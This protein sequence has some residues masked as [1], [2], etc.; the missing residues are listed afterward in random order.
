MYASMD[1]EGAAARLVV[2]QK[3]CKDSEQVL[4]HLHQS[5]E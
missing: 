2:V 1:P 3:T 5:N 4:H